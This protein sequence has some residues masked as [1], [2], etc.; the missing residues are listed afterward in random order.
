LRKL[1]CIERPCRSANA[2]QAF[3]E[4][5]LPFDLPLKSIVVAVASPGA[6]DLNSGMTRSDSSLAGFALW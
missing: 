1:R 3:A 6:V 4:E 5:A 2:V